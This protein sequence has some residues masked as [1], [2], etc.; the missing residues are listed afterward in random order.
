MSWNHWEFRETIQ[1]S[2]YIH[3][4]GA[5]GKEISQLTRFSTC[6]HAERSLIRFQ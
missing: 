6:E 1:P 5:G 3:E 4:D 2:M